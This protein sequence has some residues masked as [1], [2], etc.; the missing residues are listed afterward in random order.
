M[1][2]PSR[3]FKVAQKLFIF[4]AWCAG[5]SI[6]SWFVFG[7]IDA[8]FVPNILASA[9][10]FETISQSL[11]T[12]YFGV[13]MIAVP[14]LLP[15][16]SLFYLIVALFSGDGLDNMALRLSTFAVLACS[17]AILLAVPDELCKP[18]T[19]DAGVCLGYKLG[20][21]FDQLSKGIF[22]DIFDVFS[23][24]LSP[25][26]LDD[27]GILAKIYVLN[28]RM[29]SALYVVALIMFIYQRFNKNKPDNVV[30]SE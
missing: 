2:Q 28:F 16:F 7:I 5:F 18:L 29:L 30:V 27:M 9:G 14:A 4:S 20:F 1:S 6:L 17:L 12:L 8:F 11:L 19:E 26:S 22:A 25:L 13:V 23:L 15:F 21:L 10:S 3:T 24:K